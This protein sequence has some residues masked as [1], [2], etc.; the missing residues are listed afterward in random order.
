MKRQDLTRP[1]TYELKSHHLVD[2]TGYVFIKRYLDP[3]PIPFLFLNS[4]T[5]GYRG[6][7]SDNQEFELHSNVLH[8]RG[9]LRGKRDKYTFYFLS[10]TKMQRS[11]L[12]GKFIVF[13]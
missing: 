1:T 11:A 8:N 7:K 12:G 4:I 5:N 13:K 9:I 2:L 6:L 10:F 3:R